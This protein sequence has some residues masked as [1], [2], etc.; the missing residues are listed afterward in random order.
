MADEELELDVNQAK[1]GK[2]TTIIIIVLLLLV[3]ALG[4]VAAWLLLSKGDSADAGDSKSPE[5]AAEKLPLQYLTI[6]PEF[7]VNFGPDQPVRYMQVDLMISSRDPEALKKIGTY[8]PIL[9]NDLLVAISSKTYVE[10][11]TREG[12]QNL[13]KKI[14]NT[15]NHV[16]TTAGTAKAGKPPE[17]DLNDPTSEVKGPI[18]N[19]YYQSF[20]MQ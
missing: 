7:V 8:M 6:Q 15:I 13:Q 1:G 12:K 18:E 16:L 4:G 11:K 20:I 3:L 9:R 14:L 5:A 19:V 10:L 2:T 17:V